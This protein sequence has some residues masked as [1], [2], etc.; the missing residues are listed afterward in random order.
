MSED[1]LQ[2]TVAGDTMLG[3]LVDQFFQTH[4]TTA[5]KDE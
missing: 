5:K 2:F 3:R 4:I 1:E